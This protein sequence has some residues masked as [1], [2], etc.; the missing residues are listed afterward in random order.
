VARSVAAS[1]LVK[2]AVHG[3]DPNWGRIASAAGQSGAE[4][5]PEGLAIRIGGQTVYDGAPLPY[6]EERASRDLLAGVVELRLDLRMGAGSGE[7]WGCDLSAE[8]VA[9]NS[10]YRT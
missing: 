9:I 7:A 6:D 5:A 8:Y 3:G 2:A 4:L 10:E 1:N